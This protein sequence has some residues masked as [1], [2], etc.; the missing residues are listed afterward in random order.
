MI[1]VV[2]EKLTKSLLSKFFSNFS[3]SQNIFLRFRLNTGEIELKVEP[4]EKKAGRIF[5]SAGLRRA[6]EAAMKKRVGA[7]K[8]IRDYFWTYLDELEK[9]SSQ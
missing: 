3:C 5:E 7:R 6:V 8:L 2:A 9:I 1:L 4:Q